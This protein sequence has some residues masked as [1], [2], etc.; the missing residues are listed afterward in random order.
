VGLVS[1]TPLPLPKD[2][3]IF[4]LRA[5][6]L[7][8]R[9]RECRLPGG[10]VA[11]NLVMEG[12][13]L[14]LQIPIAACLVMDKDRQGYLYHLKLAL[15]ALPEGDRNLIALFISKGRGAPQ[16]RPFSR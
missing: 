8:V 5:E 3:A 15:D 12:H 2:A 7:T 10:L 16:I 9:T 14:P 13:S 6:A 1:T 4:E 11:L